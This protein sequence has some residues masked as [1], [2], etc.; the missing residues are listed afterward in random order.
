MEKR[1]DPD[2]QPTELKTKITHESD[3]QACK[4]TISSN[5]DSIAKYKIIITKIKDKKIN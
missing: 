3:E 4:T 5:S 1:I 2:H